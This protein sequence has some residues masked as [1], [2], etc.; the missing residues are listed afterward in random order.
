MH[1]AVE[2]G[3]VE[4]IP[5]LLS[6]KSHINEKTHENQTPLHLAAAN[7]HAETVRILLKQ[8]AKSNLKNKNNKTAQCLTVKK[9]RSANNRSFF[10]NHEK[11]KY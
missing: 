5:L 2:C 11:N 1:F 7:G 6:A 4:I 10:G 3:N 8:G 9:R